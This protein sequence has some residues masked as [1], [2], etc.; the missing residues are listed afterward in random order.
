MRNNKL[1][2]SPLLAAMALGLALVG[3]SKKQKTDG[4]VAGDTAVQTTDLGA[5][6]LGAGAKIPQL[7]TVY[8]DYDSFVINAASKTQLDA[9]AEWLKSN[10]SAK[11]QIEG[12]TDERGTTEYNL[13]LGERRSG[14]V[15]DYL[16]SKGV[17]AGQLSTI[18]YGEERPAVQGSDEAAWSKNRRAEFVSGQ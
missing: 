16:I 2:K 17:P 10:S 9:N 8:F 6:T 11:V 1:L 4:D 18:S 7:S 14:A 12:H 15:K 13:A 5:S 3:C